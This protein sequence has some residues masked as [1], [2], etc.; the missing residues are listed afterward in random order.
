MVKAEYMGNPKHL[1]LVAHRSPEGSLNKQA[2]RAHSR[3]AALS[4][5]VTSRYIINF[6]GVQ[7]KFQCVRDIVITVLYQYG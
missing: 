3:I 5:E 4:L 7:Q 1:R 6:C 2:Q